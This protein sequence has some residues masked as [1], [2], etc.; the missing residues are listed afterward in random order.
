MCCHIV[1]VVIRWVQ[2][3]ASLLNVC[4]ELNTLYYWLCL[5]VSLQSVKTWNGSWSMAGRLYWYALIEGLSIFWAQAVQWTHPTIQYPSV[6]LTSDW[7]LYRGPPILSLETVLKLPANPR[8]TMTPGLIQ[9]HQL[10]RLRDHNVKTP[11][12]QSITQQHSFTVQKV[13]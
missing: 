6:I 8:A 7:D 1:S 4:L 10:I 11:K 12:H 5:L 3:R 2:V 9:Y 13:A